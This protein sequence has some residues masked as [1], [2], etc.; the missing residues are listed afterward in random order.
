MKVFL[1]CLINTLTADYNAVSLTLGVHAQRGFSTVCLGVC[2][3]AISST[4]GY[5]AA[6]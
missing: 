5:E 1:Q 4:S 6:D 3:D 2:V